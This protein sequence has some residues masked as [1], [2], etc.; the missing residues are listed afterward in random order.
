V[1][2]HRYTCGLHWREGVILRYEGH[3]ARVELNPMLREVRLVV[4]GAQPHNFFTIVKNTFDLILARF[5]GLRIRRAVPCICHWEQEDQPRCSHFY[6]Y[7]NL[8]KRLENKH[9]KVQCDESFKSVSVRTLLF[10]IHESTDDLVLQRLE[11]NQQ[12]LLTLRQGQD[13]LL[14]QNAQMREL[15]NRNF[16]R[17]WNLEMRKMEAECPNTFFLMPGSRNR[18]DPRNWV[19]QQYELY[20]VC[21]HPPQLHGV[22]SGYTLRQSEAWWIGMRPWLNY[23][24]QFLKHSVPLGIAIADVAYDKSV[25]DNMKNS[26]K[27]MEEIVK[28][29]PELPAL[30][31]TKLS[32]SLPQMSEDQQLAGS[33]LRIF[34]SFLR[35]ADP[36]Q[37]WGDLQKTITPDGN[38][39]WLCKEHRVQYEAMPLLINGNG[40]E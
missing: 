1:R 5:E 28:L 11:E 38:I 12:L 35:E 8:V 23:L 2:T 36:S 21:Q 6:H 26:L 17:L 18:F 9:F 25:M 10:G 19:S 16:M 3:T 4:W 30:D 27:L 13:L 32:D 29:L 31:S 40:E 39:L 33:S 14:E 20:L 34:H 37:R 7:E 22:G 24:I 15:L